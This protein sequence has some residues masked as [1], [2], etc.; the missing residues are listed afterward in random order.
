VAGPADE[1]AAQPAIAVAAVGDVHCRVGR[2]DEAAAAFAPL[3][4]EADL[5]LL[6]GDLTANGLVEEAEILVDSC[7]GLG[8]PVCAVL[9]NHDWHEGNQDAISG[10]LADAGITVLERGPAALEVG[11]LT[12][13][14]A[15]A[16][17]YAGGFPGSH[18]VDY[19]EPSLRA[20]Y[21]ETGGEVE[22]LDEG[23]RAIAA[24][25]LRLAVLH[26]S[27]TGETLTGEPE[28][29]WTFLGSDRLAAPLLQHEPDL[30]VHG[31]AHAG[32]FEG[33]V[34]SVPVYNVAVPVLGREYHL[35]R[36]EAP[37]AGS[38]VH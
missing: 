18:L 14:V 33:R 24:C 38:P 15:G 12:V 22:H 4:T 32:S 6:A 21:R 16:K 34:G 28:G 26:Y 5:L 35:F 31:H 29:I 20:V 37:A 19:G 25:D 13:G 17:G 30:A 23:L 3:A 8:I 11:G 2:E 9:G 7:R 10:L 1:S 27:P 36:L